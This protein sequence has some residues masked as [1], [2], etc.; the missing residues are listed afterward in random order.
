MAWRSQAQG[1]NVPQSLENLAQPHVD[2][3]DYFLGEG[4]EQVIESMDPVEVRQIGMERR[5]AAAAAPFL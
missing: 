2:S 1:E 5:A 4:M 3:F